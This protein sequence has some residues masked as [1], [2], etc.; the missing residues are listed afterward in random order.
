MITNYIFKI[1]FKV[2]TSN[3][4]KMIITNIFKMITNIFKVIT[5]NIFKMA[6]GT[7][8]LKNKLCLSQNYTLASLIGGIFTR[9]FKIELIRS[10]F[11]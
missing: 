9:S 11:I 4:F 1:I 10:Y 7:S 6:S 5:S 3:I 2:I 8:P